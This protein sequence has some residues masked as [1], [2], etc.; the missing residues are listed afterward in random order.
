[1]CYQSG[2]SLC[3]KIGTMA[4]EQLVMPLRS[5][6]SVALN[7]RSLHSPDYLAAGDIAEEV[8]EQYPS[9]RADDIRA[10]FLLCHMVNPW[11]LKTPPPA[12]APYFQRTLLVPSVSFTFLRTVTSCA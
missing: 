10:V 4:I 9:L 8:S 11:N 3:R 5:V 6:S 1:M 12:K 2:K 7:V